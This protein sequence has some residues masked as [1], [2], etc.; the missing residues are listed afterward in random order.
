MQ[1]EIDV[2]VVGGGLSGLAAA[3]CLARNGKRVTVFEQ[4]DRTGGRARTNRFNG[5]YFNLGPHALYRGGAGI[6]VLR[7]FGIEPRG[8]IPP[9]TGAVAV[10][11]GSKHTLPSGPL[12]LLSTSLLTAGEKIETAKLLAALPRVDPQPLYHSTLGEWVDANVSRPRVREFLHAVFR[13]ATYVNAPHLMS[14]GVALLQVQKALKTGVLYLDSGWQSLVDAL[15]RAARA[16]GVEI[17]TGQRVEAIEVSAT[18]AV[19]GVRLADGRVA[20]AIFAVVAASPRATRALL[21]N[22]APAWLDR[23]VEGAV[24][25]RAACLDVGLNRL[26]DPRVTFALGVDRAMYLSVHSAWARLAPEGGR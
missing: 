23:F 5:F 18:G 26:P 1:R 6:G 8:G 9:A 21:G 11:E 2:A 4:A 3:I 20:S 10:A 15:E 16:A 13:V 14:A 24:P 12:S 22:A 17:E 19:A 25:V 7:E